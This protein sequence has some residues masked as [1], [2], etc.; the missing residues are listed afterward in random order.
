MLDRT[1]PVCPTPC[2]PSL[3]RPAL[4]PSPACSLGPSPTSEAG[5]GWGWGG[6]G[7]RGWA[8]VPRGLFF[9][10]SISASSSSVLLSCVRHPSARHPSLLTLLWT[11]TLTV[12][13]EVAASQRSCPLAS[14]RLKIAL[15]VIT[16]VT[17]KSLVGVCLGVTSDVSPPRTWRS[18][19]TQR[20]VAC[21]PRPCA[22]PPSR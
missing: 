9:L 10:K 22:R 13:A 6:T 17:I 8:W 12:L 4:P 7:E 3:S 5:G 19:S 18:A 2:P 15:Q 11:H 21:R 20:A 1:R 16:P 14:S